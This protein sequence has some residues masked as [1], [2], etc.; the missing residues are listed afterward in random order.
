MNPATQT[1]SR[2]LNV[3]AVALILHSATALLSGQAKKPPTSDD[4]I[5]ARTPTSSQTRFAGNLGTTTGG[6]G[7]QGDSLG[8][9]KGVVDSGGGDADALVLRTI[10]NSSAGPSIDS[11]AA[12]NAASYVTTVAPGSIA[13]AFGS[14]LLSSP[15]QPS[16]L[17]LPDS[18]G[19]LSMQFGSDT[20]S[21]L[22]YVSGSQVNFQVPWELAGQ[23]QAPLS[24]AVNGQTSTPQTANIAPFAPGI[25][26]MNGQGTGQGA[27]L[28][29][30]N[31][32]ANSSNPA[33]AGKTVVQI[34]CTGLGAVTNQ[35]V[36]GSPAPSSPLA[37]TI[38]TPTVSIG[39]APAQVHFSGLVPGLVGEYQVNASVPAAAATGNAVPVTL[40]IGGVTS[41][42][43]TMAVQSGSS[44]AAS[45]AAINPSTSPA[46]RTFTAVISGSNTSFVQGQTLASF[47]P[48]I[49]VGGASEGQAGPVIVTTPTNAS[50]QLTI[51]PA[52]G[53]GARTV[54]V[55]TGTQT[56][57]LS[58][59]FTV[60]AL[61]EALAPLSVV[62]SSP[63][64]A[65]VGVSQASTIQIAFNEALDPATVG[66]A[67][68]MLANGSSVLTATVAYDSANNLVTLTPAGLLRPQNTYT[69]T[70]SSLVR[71]VVENS[72]GAPYAFSF[73]TVPPASVTGAI[74]SPSGLDPSTLSVV[75]FGGTLTSPSP[76]GAFAATLSPA[77]TGLVAA[78][79]PGK[80]FGLLAVTIA[81]SP[82]ASDGPQNVVTSAALTW[83]TSTPV[84]KTRWQVTASS[85]AASTNGG[86]VADLQ[87]TAEALV[88]IS[89][90]LL[91]ADPRRAPTIMSA[92][93]GNPAT[94]QLAQAL[95]QSWNEAAPLNDASVKS[96]RE[97]AIQA[98]VQQLTQTPS[99]PQGEEQ[100]RSFLR[101]ALTSPTGSG[102]ASG[103]WSPPTVAVTPNCWPNLSANGSGLPCL[104]LDYISL[105][106]G[107]VTVDQNTGNYVFTPGNCTNASV[108][109]CAVG[110][111]GQA[112][113]ISAPPYSFVAMSDSFGPESPVGN[114]GV[115]PCGANATCAAWVDGNSSLQYLDVESDFIKA[116]S[117]VAQHFG[118]G[119]LSSVSQALSLPAPA[120]Q[121]A[122][123]IVRFYSGA[124]A[125]P[126]E[127]A[128]VF[129]SDYPLGQTLFGDALG[130]NALESVFNAIDALQVLPDGVT[131]CALEGTAQLL[132]QGGVT[133]S[134][135]P[136][137]TSIEQTFET[138]GSGATGQIIS[139]FQQNVVDS[140]VSL[141]G[142]LFEWSSGVDTV[143]KG[144]GAA[145]NLGQALQRVTELETSA[146]AVET[147]VIA[148]TP[149]SSVVG[150]PIPSIT[151]LSPA[152]ATAGT[153]SQVVTVSGQG[154]VSS[155]SVS[156]QGTTLSNVFIDSQ[157]LTIKIAASGLA[158]AGTL[159]VIVT[160]P[161]PGGGR[162]HPAV[163]TVQPAVAQN[164]QP[165]ISS[166]SPASATAGSGPLT[167]TINGSGFIAESTVSFNGTARTGSLVSANKLTIGL[168]ASDSATVGTYPV[169][170]TTPAPGG[171]SAT[172]AF[173]VTAPASG[174]SISPS[175]V[176]VPAAAVQTFSV[177]VSGGGAVTW[178]VQEGS[179][180]GTIT[181]AGIYTSPTTIGTFHVV[182]SDTANSAET[183]TA[184]VNVITATSY[185]VLYSFPYAFESASLIQGSDGNFY[186]TNEMI[187]FKITSSA[188]FTELAGLSSSPDAPISSLIQASDGTFYG[189]DS[190]G[191]G[192]IFEMEASGNVNT[193]YSFPSPNSGS[194]SGLWPWAGLIQAADGAFYGTT[195]AGGNTSCNPYGY[196]VPAYGP[197]NYYPRAGY[198]CGTVFKMDS[199]GNVT[200][201]YSFS[202]QSDGNFPQAPLIQG[203]DGNFYGTTSGGGA[204]GYGTVFKIDGSGD[205][206]LLHSFSKTDDA[207]PVAALLQGADGNLYGTAACVFC[208]AF[209][210]GEIFKLDRLGNN[211]TILHKF[212][213][214]DG[215]LPVAPLIQGSDGNFYGTTWAGG[216]LSCG[217]W[218]F[219]VGSN[220]PYLRLEG[221]GTVFRMDSA[222]NVTVLH[223]FEEPQSGDGDS[224]YAG[225]TFGKDGHV[226]GTTYYGGTST[227]FGTIFR[228]SV[229]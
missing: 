74:T 23:S 213:G 211:F 174:V 73:T 219:N 177:T 142:N 164:P 224:P 167:L 47:G 26:A 153:A 39:G 86:I 62:S 134:A 6:L 171:G 150:N 178:S 216:D 41:N 169:V 55:T 182:A 172:A 114:Y 24:V 165:T 227:Y 159:A 141:F 144:L 52:A 149:G 103:L 217:S 96:A 92:I 229:P 19:S 69:I 157:H 80:A 131:S 156:I 5:N 112:S 228:L 10:L 59:G 123:Y 70:V 226:Y 176:T 130:L 166:L 151:S 124:I 22:F 163:F 87:T 77:G 160:N 200:V 139:C 108:L 64:N 85:G 51:D 78:M 122:D 201:L 20:K 13:A 209:S 113:I 183:A 109:G 132:I 61:P 115:E 145:S 136:T 184:T 190:E 18:L 119:S 127:T 220:Y 16:G 7:T 82:S 129:D 95:A 50:V 175:S 186:G 147:A 143:I 8:P 15:L 116:V 11:R 185:S 117:L 179:L 189:V 102:D 36:S 111:L 206:T 125:D 89:P 84:R 155:S 42:T 37:K 38:T 9:P 221:C 106:P 49:S 135:S 88:F 196:G 35:P 207:S 66:P 46:G 198:G 181:S 21:P 90:Y 162:S 197:F 34:F 104:D 32:L 75:S 94:V 118:S 65:A 58:N 57:N 43:V 195:Y 83:P 31:H 29:A 202:G 2:V 93:A 76:S 192:S 63:A 110:W 146:S 204:H 91:T 215:S 121:S 107:T 140:V 210:T 133:I 53:I 199:S 222:G 203:S 98:V 30:S 27:I 194:I 205:F 212:S 128:N 97:N 168:S 54:T 45:I 40:S 180:G 138:V 79:L 120:Q 218:Y 68:F 148:I 137:P 225:L 188:T 1:S 173:I 170:V 56:V 48:G 67:T 101:G 208:G 81:G 3:L 25:F 99:T 4:L 161:S 126:A 17:P 60:L 158:T 193:L 100:Q 72:L 14:F 223:D 105:Q 33:I 187:A 44:S 214:L 71:N 152:S 154:F 28:D 191:N 12:V